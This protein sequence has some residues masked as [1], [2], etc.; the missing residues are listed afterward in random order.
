MATFTVEVEIGRQTRELIER[1]A[2]RTAVQIELGPKTLEA[3][4]DVFASEPEVESEESPGAPR[5]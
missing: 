2:A 5:A 1:V 4:R 3:I